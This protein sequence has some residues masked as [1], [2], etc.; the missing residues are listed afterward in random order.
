MTTI[1]Q[2]FYWIKLPHLQQI[3]E[4]LTCNGSIPPPKMESAI[5]CIY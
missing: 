1:M 4:V 5:N 3:E 2:T